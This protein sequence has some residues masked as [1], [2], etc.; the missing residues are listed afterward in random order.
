M[1]V[2]MINVVLLLDCFNYIHLLFFYFLNFMCIGVS[3]I[4]VESV[5]C[6]GTGVTDSCELPLWVL[7]VKPDPLE[8][9][10]VPLTTEP[11]LQPLNYI[12]VLL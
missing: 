5:R 6:P 12:H 1:A 11:S 4:H 3:C 8:E 10:L 7:G 2:F 9:Q